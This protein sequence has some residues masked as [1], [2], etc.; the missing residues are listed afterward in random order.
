MPEMHAFLASPEGAVRTRFVKRF[1]PRLWTVDFPRPMMAAIGSSRPDVL[2]VDLDF[3]TRNDLAGLIWE[4]VDR[5]SHPLLAYGTSRDYRGTRLSF[6]WVA[7]AGIMPLDAVN[8]PVLTI[9]GRD[10]GGMARTWYVRLWNYA[11]GTPAD[12]AVVLDFDRLRD[13]F[14]GDGPAVFAG[15]VDR[16][17]ISLVGDGFD[18]SDAP[19]AAPLSTWVELRGI[20]SEGPSSTL[21]MGDAFLPTH[22]LRMCSGYDDSYHQAPERLVEQWHALGYR[23]LVNHYVGMSHHYAVGHV[24]G[25]RFEVSG[26]ICASAQRWHSALAAAARTHGYRLILS[27]SYEVLGMNMPADWAQRDVYGN[28]A[29]TGWDPPSALLSPCSADAMGWLSEIAARFVAIITDAGLEAHFQIGEPWWWVGPGGAPCCYDAATVAR[30]RREKGGGPPAMADVKGVRT[31]AER[32]WLGWLGARLSESTAQVREAARAA[33]G[34]T[35]FTSYLLFFTPQ[36]L[37]HDVP[38]L[39]LANMPSGWAMPEWD[40]LQ[41]EDYDFLTEGDEGA[42][43]SARARTLEALGYPAERQHYLGGFV[44]HPEEADRLWPVIAQEMRAGFARGVAE[45]LVWA[46]PQV[47]RDGFVWTEIEG[48]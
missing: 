9:E 46:W 1:A 32:A 34:G 20:R 18:G 38:D 45:T 16:M 29:L 3:L 41:L 2:R 10:A 5:W 36:V 13:G 22:R 30:W 28:L 44:L 31:D 11:E 7:A 23:D 33:S 6:R 19:L 37:G 47:A 27:L 26:G 14:G 35:G 12:C 39:H 40:V 24:G 8:G 15:D 21:K 4:S 17:F 42:M 43:L 48:D 25:G